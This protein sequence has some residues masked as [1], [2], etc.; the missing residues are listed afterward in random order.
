VNQGFYNI[1]IIN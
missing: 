1:S